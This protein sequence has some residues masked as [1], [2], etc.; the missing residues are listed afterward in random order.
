MKRNHSIIIIVLLVFT[1]GMTACLKNVDPI[2]SNT[3]TVTFNN[4][5]PK[6]ITQ[7]ITLNP[8]DSF[9][10]DYTITCPNDMKY[11][12]VQ[13]NGADFIRDTLSDAQ[14][15]SYSALKKIGTD[16]AAGVYTYKIFV[17]NKDGIYLGDKTI[18]VTISADFVYYTVRNLYVPDSTAKTNKT[19]FASSNGKT[20]SYADG[21]GNSNLIDF[22]YFYDTTTVGVTVAN[23]PKHTIYALSAST[24]VQYDLTGWTKN[25]TIFKKITTPTFVNIT[26][27][28]LLRQ[29]CIAALASGTSTKI[30]SA[31]I[32][33]G[34]LTGVVLAFKTAA[35]KYGIMTVNYTS[36][37][38]AA[39]DTFINIDVKIEP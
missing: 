17:K 2:K 11:V 3:I 6:T 10:L 39:H 33:A 36:K 16:S 4:S 38:G 26:S 20:Y 22:G 7:D 13:K 31:G 34:N 29:T 21:P 23:Q 25:A 18:T 35:G 19:Y 32:S 24:P 12:S 14:K 30:T 1:A 37:D 15:H 27:K 9:Y 5:V 28:A 8:K